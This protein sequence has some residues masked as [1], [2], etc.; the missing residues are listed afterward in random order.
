MRKKTMSGGK[1][2]NITTRRKMKRIRKMRKG[3]IIRRKIR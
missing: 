2:R 3:E 1:M